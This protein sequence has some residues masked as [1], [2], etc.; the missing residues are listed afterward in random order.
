MEVIS[1]LS[2]GFEILNDYTSVLHERVR[3]EPNFSVLLRAGFVKLSSILE[4]PLTRI[5]QIQSPDE[6]SVAEFY[7]GELVDFMRRVLDIIPRSVFEILSRI[8]Q[9]QTSQL[10]SLPVKFESQ[11]LKD[12]AQL[13]ER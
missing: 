3:T 6:F 9:V 11:Y 2:Y 4:V 5:H 13:D 1:D 12:Y 7:S 10:K 8:V